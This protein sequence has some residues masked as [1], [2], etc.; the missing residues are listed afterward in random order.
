MYARWHDGQRFIE[1]FET[2]QLR[3]CL[4]HAWIERQTKALKRFAVHPGSETLRALRSLC[5]QL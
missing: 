1:T 2:W 5:A 4:D 3:I